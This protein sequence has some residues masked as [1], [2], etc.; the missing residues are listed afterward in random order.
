MFYLTGVFLHF[1]GRVKYI[2]VVT[3]PLL[4][5]GNF[6]NLRSVV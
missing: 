3:L 2:E 4:K 6:T 1:Q 5:D